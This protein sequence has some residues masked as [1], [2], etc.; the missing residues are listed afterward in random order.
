MWRRNRILRAFR[1]CG[2]G[3]LRV[4]DSIRRN[5]QC[6]RRE[7]R[8]TTQQ[9]LITISL[10]KKCDDSFRKLVPWY[11]LRIAVDSIL[12]RCHSEEFQK[13][14]D[15]VNSGCWGARCGRCRK[16]RSPLQRKRRNCDVWRELRRVVR[17]SIFPRFDG[18]C[19]G[20]HVRIRQ[21]SGC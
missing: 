12:A 3:T 21:K 8:L 1:I 20:T 15:L 14:E 13:V 2:T 19:G 4:G 9:S 18:I 16:C 10:A 7:F 11:R 17:L 5:W 6:G